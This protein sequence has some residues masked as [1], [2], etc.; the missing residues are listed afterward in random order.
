[1]QLVSGA[2]AASD[3]EIVEVAGV[4]VQA[5]EVPPAPVNELR[6]MAD[7]LR[8][9]MGS[10]VVVLAT[11]DAVEGKVMLVV[12]V[13]KDLTKRLQAGKII[14][15]LAGMVGG[16]GGGRPDFAQAG[17]KKPDALPA[18]LGKVAEVVGELLG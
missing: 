14:K 6:D 8:D 12:T 16:G 10:G 7:A 13:S 15:P 3:E 18:M 11:R 4:K 1:M 5:R 17:G 9:K 2:A